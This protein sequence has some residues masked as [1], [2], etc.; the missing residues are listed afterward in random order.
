ME[1]LYRITIDSI[2]ETIDSSLIKRV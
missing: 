2:D 1:L